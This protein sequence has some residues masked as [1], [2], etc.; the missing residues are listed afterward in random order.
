M[1]MMSIQNLWITFHQKEHTEILVQKYTPS[2]LLPVLTV[3]REPL[4]L[5]LFIIFSTSMLNTRRNDTTTFPDINFLNDQIR[6]GK[7][8]CNILLTSKCN[9]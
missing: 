4:I 9:R 1:K 7:T 2:D 8:L 5:F 6:L 3:F